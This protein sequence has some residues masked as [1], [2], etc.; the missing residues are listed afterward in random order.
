MK[1][2]RRT[3]QP[4]PARRALRR[5][6]LP[7]L[8]ALLLG[9]STLLAQAIPGSA[10]R[11][12]RPGNTGIQGDLNLAIYV[13]PDGDPW[14]GGFDSSFEEGGIAKLV[15]A[16][17]RW[18]NVSNVDYPVIGHPDTTGTTR[19]SDIV[20]DAQGDL[21]MST[22]RGAL[23]MDPAIGGSSLVNFAA[24]SPALADGGSRDLDIAPDG[25]IW[26]ALIGYGGAQ[27]GVVRHTP[28]T[29]D[30]H[31]WTGG[32]APQG[33]NDWPQ[34]VWSVVRVAVQPKPGG[35]Y[36]VWADSE[37]SSA[38]VAFDSTT[39]LWTLYEFDFVPGAMLELPGK[40]SVDEAGNVWMRRFVQFAGSTPVYSLDYRQPDGSWVSPPQVTLPEVTPPI[41]AFHAY[42]TA[43]AL[44]ADATSRVWQFHGGAWEDLGTWGAGTDTLSLD[45][46][47]DGNVWAAGAGGAAKRDVVSGLWQRH[48][49]TNSGQFD[50]SN[51]DLAIDPATGDVYAC[52][53]AGPGVGGMT[54][55][56]GVRWTG[57][58]NAQ[59]GL[60]VAWP[61]PN[62]NCQQVGYRSTVPAV[63][64]NPTNEG[65]HQWDATQ[66]SDLGGASESRGLVEDSTGRLWSLGPYYDLRYLDQ[67][68]WQPVDNN[69]AWGNN[70]QRDPT[71]PGTIWAST[72][73]EIIRTDGTYRF[74]RTYDQF[75]ELDIQVDSF[76][77]VA[78]APQGI[79]WLGSTQGIFR[80]D[81]N[82]GSYQYFSALGGISAMAASPFTV[83]PDGKLW[84]VVFDPFGTGPHGLVWFDGATAG[85]YS[86]PRGGEPQWGGLPHAQ[87]VALEVRIV[88]GGYELWMS[89]LSRGIAV[90]FVPGANLFGDGFESGDLGRW[91]AT[92]P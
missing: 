47:Q 20:A 83:T 58:N 49:V 54:R 8:A 87:I 67:A 63:V 71:R 74:S 84:Y 44:L 12:Y 79:A 86:A 45:I 32:A 15:Q 28:G 29:A 77:T 73:A 43:E 31:Y 61:F 56:D 6:T 76:T 88:P 57:F 92:V 5:R 17:N 3:S 38:L 40:D 53:N 39:Q 25:T 36:L 33:G 1:A 65:H 7:L 70:L 22:W 46:D 59:Y 2:A 27:G 24:A 75:P 9:A 48:R 85:I 10:W 55:F 90:L 13:G 37:N 72:F 19:V 81:A 11:Y 60:G 66:W 18:I 14:I 30:W 16:E 82:S 35:G 52:A 41:S 91:S 26:F 42:G 80:L 64:L 4:L 50:T 68:T 34:L 21:W 69:G 51:S 89:C 78:A 62:D 23:K